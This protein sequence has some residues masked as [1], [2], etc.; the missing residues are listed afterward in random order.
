MKKNTLSNKDRRVFLKSLA[1]MP[2][3]GSFAGSGEARATTGVLAKLVDTTKCIGA[4]RCKSACDSWNRLPAERT[5]ELTGRTFMVVKRI[6]QVRNR[7]KISFLKWQCQHCQN[8]A[9]ARVCPTKA[10]RKFDQGAVVI[11]EDKCIAC[12]SCHLACPFDVPKFDFDMG[13]TRKCHLCFNRY[14]GLRYHGLKSRTWSKP[15]CVG[16]C[17]VSALDFGPREDMIRKARARIRD[18][19]GY[20]YGVTEAG[21]T[22]VLT[23]LREEPGKMGMVAPPAELYYHPAHSFMSDV[24]KPLIV[25]ALGLSGLTVAGMLAQEIATSLRE[26]SD[27]DQNDDQKKEG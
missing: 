18:V 13:V 12:G 1:L 9:C 21:G 10:I 27:D 23:I 11:V 22:D 24:A 3:A 26:D 5:T 25:I 7:E 20:L 17:P 6:S 14:T 2:V 19:G 4:L 8:P 15:A 16:S